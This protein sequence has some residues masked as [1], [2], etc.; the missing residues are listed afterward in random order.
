MR[1]LDW[2]TIVMKLDIKWTRFRYKFWSN[3]CKYAGDKT[4]DIIDESRFIT[5]EVN[6]WYPELKRECKNIIPR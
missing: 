6:K 4:L 2:D 1:K 3:L 5:D